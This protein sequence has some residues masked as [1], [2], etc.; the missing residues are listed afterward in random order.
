[1]IKT[2]LRHL[3]PALLTALALF[4]SGCATQKGMIV[5]LPE[6]GKP[7]GK[8]M[9]S[10]DKGTRVLDK[11]WEAVE[12]SG[13]EKPPGAPVVMKE[14]EVKERFG[15]VLAATPKPPAHFLLY[16]KLD[17]DELVP[18]SRI[19]LLEIATVIRERRP[20]LVSVVGH[21]DTVGTEAYN[22]Q[23]G[24]RRAHAVAAKLRALG[25]VMVSVDSA[26]RGK[27]E[28]LVKTPDQVYEPRN[29]RAE[30]TVR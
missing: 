13:K 24:L 16:F 26:S 21:T 8:V 4:L 18:Q 15:A 6:K 23:L 2:S 9:V 1:M 19:V 10:T 28:L 5:L 27:T 14:N 11:S 7:S 3:L 22:F 17:S 20:A 12:I 29:R 25:A 30:V